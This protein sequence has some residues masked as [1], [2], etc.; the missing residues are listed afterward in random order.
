FGCRVP[1][2]FGDLWVRI[3]SDAIARTSN[4]LSGRVYINCLFEFKSL[5][6]TRPYIFT[7]YQLPNLAWRLMTD[8]FFICARDILPS[9]SSPV[10]TRQSTDQGCD[11]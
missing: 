10:G 9:L 1:T 2:G 11:K 4:I 5:G 6:E 3:F 8:D 7:N